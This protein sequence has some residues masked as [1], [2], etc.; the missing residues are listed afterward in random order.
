MNLRS[1]KLSCAQNIAV[2]IPILRYFMYIPIMVIVFFLH[3]PEV[4]WKSPLSTYVVQSGENFGVQHVCNPPERCSI[5]MCL[6]L[7]V[8]YKGHLKQSGRQGFILVNDIFLIF[9]V[10]P[11]CLPIFF[12]LFVNEPGLG[13]LIDLAWLWNHFHLVLDET[14]FEPVTFQSWI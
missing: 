2:Q 3:V 4:F 9:L 14:R 8:P 11:I 13:T 7:P 5:V 1:I 6:Y 12:F 10:C